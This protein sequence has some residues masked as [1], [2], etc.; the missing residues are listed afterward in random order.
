MAFR[1]ISK[2]AAAPHRLSRTTPMIAEHTHGA[3]W[4]AVRLIMRSMKTLVWEAPR[5]MSCGVFCR[6][7]RPRSRSAL[8]SDAGKIQA[9]TL[10]HFLS[11]FSQPRS[12]VRSGVSYLLFA[13]SFLCFSKNSRIWGFDLASALSA[14]PSGNPLRSKFI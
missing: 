4:G 2:I 1:G 9:R 6:Q 5:V 12:L 11:L 14:S 8:S 7:W 3:S 10:D 13:S